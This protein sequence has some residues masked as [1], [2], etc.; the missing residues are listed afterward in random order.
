M[1]EKILE[2]AC[3]NLE[4]ALIAQ[5]SGADRIELCED[6]EQGGITPSEDLVIEVRNRIKIPI[7]VIVRPRGGDFIYS[8]KELEEM[9][10]SISFC[11]KN[12]VD[13]V[14]W[15]IL[16]RNK[17]INIEAN[18]LLIKAA[19]PMSIT[20]HRAID[21]CPDLDTAIRNLIDLK[22]DRVLTS[23]LAISAE[24]GIP[25]LKRIQNEFGKKITIMPGG[26]LRSSNIKQLLET[27]CHEF[28]SS[29]ITHTK[30]LAD[31]SE[32]KG[33]RLFLK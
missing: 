21:I 30:D 4:S 11:K 13:G 27:G 25:E 2:I 17:E 3:F 16:T 19:R 12:N 18:K 9:K 24:E 22:V 7:H 23:G 31:G 1:R 8:E 32:I 33:L 28:H 5:S 10:Q 15:G 14:V 26:G 6:Y 29:A 20:F